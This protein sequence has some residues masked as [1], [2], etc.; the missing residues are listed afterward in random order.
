MLT[1]T[2]SVMTTLY[3]LGKEAERKRIAEDIE[4]FLQK[5]KHIEKLDWGANSGHV[6]GKPKHGKQ[7]GDK[8]DG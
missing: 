1:T 4:K 6:I 7:H 3:D 5:G 8:N 2:T